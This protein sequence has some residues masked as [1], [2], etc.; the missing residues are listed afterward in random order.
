MNNIFICNCI[1]GS[2]CQ[3]KACVNCHSNNILYRNWSHVCTSCNTL[4]DVILLDPFIICDKHGK[5]NRD[6]QECP[7]CERD[8]WQ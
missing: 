7:K 4:Q 6:K 5:F 8:F 2:K 1:D 3:Y